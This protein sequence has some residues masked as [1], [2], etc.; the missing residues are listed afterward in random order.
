M[1]NNWEGAQGVL[2]RFSVSIWVIMTGVYFFFNAPHVL[3]I[4]MHTIKFKFT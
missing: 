3:L 1:D 4:F 2:Q